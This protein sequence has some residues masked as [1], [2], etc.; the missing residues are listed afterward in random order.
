MSVADYFSVLRR[1]W[2]SILLAVLIGGLG[3]YGY[4]RTLPKMYRSFASVL[5]IPERGEST[6]ELV[7]G[8]SYVQ[9]IVQSYAL[10]ATS[11]YVLAPVIEELGLDSSPAALA[12]QLSVETPL[13]TVVI[14]LAVT[15]GS[16]EEAQQIAGAITEQL[17]SAVA[18][19]SPRIGDEP[20]V[21][22]Q[23]ISPPTL[24]KSFS[25]PDFRLYGAAGAGAGL[26]LA[27]GAAFVRQRLRLRPSR[28]DE[29]AGVIDVPLLGEVP[30]LSRQRALPV[31]LREVKAGLAAEAVR[32]VTANLRFVSV[33]QNPQ[34]ILVT[35]AR[36]G[37]GKTSMSAALA[38]T[39][40]EA[41]RRT[42]VIDADLRHPSLAGALGIESGVGLTTLLLNDC[43]ME[44][45]V[46]TWGHPLLDVMASGTPSPNPG[47]I[48]SAGLLNQTI[49][50]ARERYD[51]VIIDTPPVLAVSDAVWIAPQTDGVMFVMRAGRTRVSS[52][53]A[54]I[55]AVSATQVM[56]LG[57]VLNGT[58]M[59]RDERYHSGGEKKRGFWSRWLRRGRELRRP[60]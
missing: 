13:N 58:R 52:L 54:A 38:L 32:A 39:I 30:R 25:A 1:H 12:S 34:V 55:D 45:A 60:R 11:P 10:L 21:R 23:T 7:Q 28:P 42:L 59:R 36:S 29:L 3:A 18:E 5:V 51:A 46:Q 6:S 48:A 24:P 40:A 8:S 31:E 4:A 20:A 15:A 57:V 27:V 56:V 49:Q 41:G 9:N 17:S 50:Q 16:P 37:D 53:K 14:E 35:S 47:Q 2:L 19:L 26:V 43:T 44:E 22:L 33:G